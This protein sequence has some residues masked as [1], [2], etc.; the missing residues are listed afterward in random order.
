VPKEL[1]TVLDFKPNL[2]VYCIK[3]LSVKRINTSEYERLKAQAALREDFAQSQVMAAVFFNP[4]NIAKRMN[5]R[6]TKKEAMP[7]APE[8]TLPP[9]GDF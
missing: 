8:D 1:P 9:E 2:S 5:F 3:D 4:E 6:W 7:V